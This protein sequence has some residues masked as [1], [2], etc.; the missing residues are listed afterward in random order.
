MR[1]R[2]DLTQQEYEI[3]SCATPDGWFELSSAE[4][5]DL[6]RFGFAAFERIPLVR[7]E[8]DITDAQAYNILSREYYRSQD[9]SSLMYDVLTFSGFYLNCVNDDEKYN[10]NRSQWQEM[11]NQIEEKMNESKTKVFFVNDII[12][13]CESNAN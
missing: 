13:L 1:R 5:K 10:Y 8:E 12:K 4:K 2:I 6:N 7:I 9:I 3:V 11:M